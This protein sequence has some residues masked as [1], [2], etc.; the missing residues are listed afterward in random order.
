MPEIADVGAAVGGALHHGGRHRRRRHAHVAADRDRAGL[1]VLDVGAADRVRALLVELGAV[2]AAD[3]VRL[4]DPRVEHASIVLDLA[5]SRRR[6]VVPYPSEMERKLATV[7][8]VDLVGSTQLVAS[9]DPEVVRSRLTRFFDQVSHCIT[10]HG[11]IVEKFAGDAVM[12]AF[13][14]PLAHEDDPERAV[15]AALAIV[16]AVAELGLEVRIG[17]ESG[18]I[19]VGRDARRRSRPGSRST[20]RRA[21]SRPPQPGEVLLG[22]G[23]ERLTRDTVVD[24]AARGADGRGLPGRGRGLAASCRCRRRSA[25]RLVVSVPF[26]GRE[27]EL[28]L[29]HNTFARAVR[30]RR[31]HLVTVFGAAGVGKSRLAREF[32][33][34]VERSTIL[35]GPLPARTARASPTGRSPRW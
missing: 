21:C 26:V 35:V 15:R 27:E 6:V 20:R 7:L 1:E 8:F 22:P 31:V 30:D 29:L 4:E 10:A 33:A 3:V 11:G 9:A 25:G 28:E 24:D 5:A 17:I 14:V 12:A 32:V 18:E 34:G 23:V 16:D 13:G 19:V 2:E